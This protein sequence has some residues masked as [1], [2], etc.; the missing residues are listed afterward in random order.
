MTSVKLASGLYMP[1]LGLGTWELRGGKCAEVVER[2]LGLGYRHIDTAHMYRNQEA[3]GEGIRQ[4][5]VPREELFVT[6][7]IWHDALRLNQVLTQFQSCLDQLK[8]DYVDLLLIHW[9]SEAVPLEETLAA[10]DEIHASGRT[11]HIGV[12]N[13]SSEQVDAAIV[14]AGAPICTNQVEFHPGKFEESL[15]RHSTEKG[16]IITAHRPLAV[17]AVAKDAALADIGLRYKKSAVQVALRWL[18]QRRVVAIPKASSEAH[19]RDNMDIFSW[20]LTNEEMQ[21]IDGL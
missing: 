12:S 9:P 19:L 6:T 17:G 4:S 20:T 11:R 5:G 21:R 15:W 14:L 7:K 10:F 2:A 18:V 13:F 3:V 16:V 8:L 1:L